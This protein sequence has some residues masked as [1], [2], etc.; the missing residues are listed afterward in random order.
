MLLAL[1]PLTVNVAGVMRYA[2]VLDLTEDELATALAGHPRIGERASGPHHNAD[3]SA[4]EQA[5]VDPADAG[6]AR[7]YAR[8]IE[9]AG[10]DEMRINRSIKV[11]VVGDVVD[12]AVGVEVRPAGL[13][14]EHVTGHATILAASQG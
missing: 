12:V 7:A 5:G 10:S 11:G 13:E 1:T 4:R 14:E 3:A 8:R 6:V 9:A 2:R